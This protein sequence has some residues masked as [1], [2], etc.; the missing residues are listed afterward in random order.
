LFKGTH[1]GKTASWSRLAVG[2]PDRRVEV[3][4]AVDK[5]VLQTVDK[6][7]IMGVVSAVDKIGLQSARKGS[8]SVTLV[9][10]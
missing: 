7:V 3:G 2:Y 8:N 5:I 6:I 4:S 10:T 9:T 1:G